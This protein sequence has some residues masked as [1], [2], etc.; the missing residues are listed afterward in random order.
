ML[1]KLKVETLLLDP[2]SDKPILILKTD[3]GEKILPIWIGHNEAQAIAL[4]LDSI[5]APRPMTHDL[6]CNIL[7]SLEGK[8][9]QVDICD[10]KDSTFYAELVV[11]KS[12]QKYRIDARPSDAIAI[13]IR[14]NAPIFVADHVLNEASQNRVTP[15]AEDSL[16][17]WL[18]SLNPDE[19]GRYK[20]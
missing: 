20:M 16:S 4:E 2:I 6:M 14:L 15:A 19:L 17:R 5:H 10:L 9:I 1:H 13:A 11:D 7:N 18:E 3:N 12:S 8:L